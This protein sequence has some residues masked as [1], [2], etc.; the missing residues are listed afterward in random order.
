[1]MS[2]GINTF[3]R[4]TLLKYPAKSLKPMLPKEKLVFGH[5]FT[6]HMLTIDWSLQNGWEAPVIQEFGRFS[7]HPAS[8]V[9]HYGSECFEGMKA[10]FPTY[11][12]TKTRREI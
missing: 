5:T 4:K 12:D 9:F 7:I 10:Y 8:T 11:L 2:G 3:T 1:M 6:D